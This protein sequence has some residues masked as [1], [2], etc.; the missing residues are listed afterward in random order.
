MPMSWE[1]LDLLGASLLIGILYGIPVYLIFCASRVLA[2]W[3]VRRWT[4]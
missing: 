3:L 1:T 4:T 2:K